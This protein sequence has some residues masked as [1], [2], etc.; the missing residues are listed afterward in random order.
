MLDVLK[1]G[2]N[3]M[4]RPWPKSRSASNKSKTRR[5][6]RLSYELFS[7]LAIIETF[8]S[9]P[10]SGSQ[11]WR[12]NSSCFHRWSSRRFG[13]CPFYSVRVAW[14][15]SCTRFPASQECSRQRL[16]VKKRS[17]LGPH[18]RSMNKASPRPET[19]PVSCCIAPYW[20]IVS[21]WSSIIR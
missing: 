11:Y 7:S 6:W 10:E 17:A 14:D 20:K 19:E 8:A 9:S 3:S 12:F 2:P 5:H 13:F 1:S 18:P 15:F 4:K 21:S 16:G